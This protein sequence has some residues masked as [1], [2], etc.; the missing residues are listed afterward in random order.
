MSRTLQLRTTEVLQNLLPVR[1]IVVAAQV[2]LQ[3]ATQNLQ[4][5]TLADTVCSDET[6]NLTRAG[7]GQTVQLEAVGGVTVGD[8]GLQVG[9]QV[10]DGDGTEGTLLGADTATDAKG[11][12]DKGDLRF[13]G[14]FNAKLTRANHGARLLALLTTFLLR[15][16]LAFETQLGMLFPIHTFGL[17]YRSRT[18]Q[19]SRA[20]T[21]YSE[22]ENC[23]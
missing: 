13:G 10:D 18:F 12:G 20:R 5:S 8:L 15:I 23:D 16:E 4:G 2:R 7:H 22:H 11:F 1:R 21:R 9:G 17:H 6:E 14:H 19:V 3:L